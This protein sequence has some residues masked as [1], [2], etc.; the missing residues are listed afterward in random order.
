MLMV[1]CKGTLMKALAKKACSE[2]VLCLP[3]TDV[4]DD[5]VASW[6]RIKRDATRSIAIRAD[7]WQPQRNEHYIDVK[8]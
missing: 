2:L 3:C 7:F 1:P 5:A 6:P 8:D 4:L